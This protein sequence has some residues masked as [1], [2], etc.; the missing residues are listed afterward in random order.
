MVY[1]IHEDTFTQLRHQ[2]QKYIT[3]HHHPKHLFL[4]NLVP[5]T[6]KR[7]YRADCHGLPVVLKQE[8]LG[9]DRD[10]LYHEYKVGLVVNKLRYTCPNFVSTL[11]YLECNPYYKNIL[12][13][14]ISHG[15][16]V[17]HLLVEQVH[18]IH[19]KTKWKLKKHLEIYIQLC[20]ALDYAYKKYGFTHYNLHRGNVIV[21]KLHKKYK[22]NVDKDCDISIKYLAVV[23][24][25]GR[26]FT[27][28]TGGHILPSRYVNEQPN[29]HYDLLMYL[30]SVFDTYPD[31]LQRFCDFYGYKGY[32]P[33]MSLT[34]YL[35][36]IVS[37]KLLYR[38]PKETVE[39]IN[40][41]FGID[42]TAKGS[43]EYITPLQVPLQ[44]QRVK[45]LES[46]SEEHK[47]GMAKRISKTIK[48][49]KKYE[50]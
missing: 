33:Y 44:N 16:K 39:F 17:K 5:L 38:T 37:Q 7:I 49:N 41:T 31:V 15:P 20:T 32:V 22:Y 2:L 28:Q 36:G 50:S 23:I 21:Q 8:E 29:I 4:S 35:K 40:K 9:T 46:I 10:S 12:P 19:V 45:Q 43:E 1:W 25:Y 34:S 24:D 6:G 42:F 30:K 14:T 13:C 26:S 3:R 48:K 11:S 47:H 27:H 18:G